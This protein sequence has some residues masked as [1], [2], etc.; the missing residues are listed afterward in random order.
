MDLSSRERLL[1]RESGYEVDIDSEVTCFYCKRNLRITSFG[2]HFSS[3]CV[4]AQ[5]RKGIKNED[6]EARAYISKKKRNKRERTNRKKISVKWK[7]AT[8]RWER[9]IGGPKPDHR[10]LEV[11]SHNVF[12]WKFTPPT[13]Q[14]NLANFSVSIREEFGNELIPLLKVAITSF[15]SIIERKLRN[16]DAVDSLFK[17]LRPIRVRFHPDAKKRYGF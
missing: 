5:Q 13:G 6:I 7:E 4:K 3:I 10:F 9:K 1:S 12:F 2:S 17:V 8:R 11:P 16:Y 15:E 14:L